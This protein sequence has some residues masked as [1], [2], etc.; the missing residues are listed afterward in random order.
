MGVRIAGENVAAGVRRS[1][2]GRWERGD[3]GREGNDAASADEVLDAGL[4]EPAFGFGEFEFKFGDG[5]D[6]VA[7]EENFGVAGLELLGGGGGAGEGAVTFVV[8]ADGD[9]LDGAGEEG[10]VRRVGVEDLEAGFEGGELGEQ[11]KKW[12]DG[13]LE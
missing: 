3:G 9:G 12:S 5:F 6:G 10:V 1:R 13:V 11:G 7:G 2:D 8:E 4:L